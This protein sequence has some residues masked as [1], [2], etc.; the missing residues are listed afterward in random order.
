[1]SVITFDSGNAG[2]G[3][4][5]FQWGAGAVNGPNLPVGVDVR[6]SIAVPVSNGLHVGV[7][8]IEDL[9]VECRLEHQRRR[10]RCVRGGRNADDF[11][12]VESGGRSAGP[13][14]HE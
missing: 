10:W 9:P 5:E 6:V 4:D 7:A 3:P 2:R 11:D 1:M 8:R 12:E 14:H 13:W